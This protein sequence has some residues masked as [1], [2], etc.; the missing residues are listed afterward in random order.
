METKAGL[1]LHSGRF[2]GADKFTNLLTN[3]GKYMAPEANHR[4]PLNKKNFMRAVGVIEMLVAVGI[5]SPRTPGLQLCRCCLAS[6]R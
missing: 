6:W 3:W 1:A 5:L 4:I 2:A